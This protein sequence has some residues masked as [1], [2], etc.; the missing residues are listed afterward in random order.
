MKKSKEKLTMTASIIAFALAIL[1]LQSCGN[2]GPEPPPPAVLIIDTSFKTAGGADL[3]DP[4]TPGSFK[5]KDLKL[6]TRVIINGE[7]KDVDY[8]E[9]GTKVFYDDAVKRNIIQI[10]I[11]TNYNKTPLATYLNLTTNDTDTITYTF[12]NLGG[13]YQYKPDSIFYNK[14]LVWLLAEAKPNS[15]W[16]P[17]TITK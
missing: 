14:K 11:P 8:N 6:V 15:N 1:I 17:M 16:Q 12:S 10:S 4:T 13:I 9:L 3:L 2:T 5:E 7:T